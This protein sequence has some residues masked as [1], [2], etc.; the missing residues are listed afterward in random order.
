MAYSISSFT[1]GKSPTTTYPY[2][3][4][5][6]DPNGTLVN[7]IMVTDLLQTIQRIIANA[8]TSPTNSPDNAAP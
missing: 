8:G 2:G 3:Y 4:V 6:D 5:G 1:R 7:T